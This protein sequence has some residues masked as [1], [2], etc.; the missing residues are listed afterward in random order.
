M[1]QIVKAHIFEPDRLADAPPRRFG[2]SGP[3][4]GS[5]DEGSPAWQILQHRHG[6]RRQVQVLGTVLSVGQPRSKSIHSQRSPS[7]SLSRAPVNTK[8]LM[9]ARA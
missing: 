4:L 2:E 3:A 1:S 8:S 7:A 9:A 5:E 6:R